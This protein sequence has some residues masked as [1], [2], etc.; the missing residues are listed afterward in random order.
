[1][2]TGHGKSLIYQIALLVARTGKVKILPSNALAVVVSSLNALISDQL[3]FCQRLK[4]KA[5]KMEQ[6]LFGNDDKLTELQEAEVVYAL[7]TSRDGSVAKPRSMLN[8]AIFNP[9][10]RSPFSRLR[11]PGKEPLL[12][13]NR[14]SEILTILFRKSFSASAESTRFVSKIIKS[15]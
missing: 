9:W 14:Q 13:G 15:L 10:Q 3:E 6:E 2:P 12:A 8:K 5:V 4:L 1:M 11:T 7:Q